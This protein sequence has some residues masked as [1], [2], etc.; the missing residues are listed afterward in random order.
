MTRIS[1]PDMILDT[2]SVI[3][4]LHRIRREVSDRFHGDVE[5]IAHDAARRLA[6]SGRPVW[7]RSRPADQAVQVAKPPAG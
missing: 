5:A 7:V 3:E 2:E 1:D 4:E 6:E